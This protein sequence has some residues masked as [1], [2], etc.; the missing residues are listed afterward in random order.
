MTSGDLD[1]D[2]RG[3][4]AHAARAILIAALGGELLSWLVTELRGGELREA[5]RQVI[6]QTLF[7]RISASNLLP[8]DFKW[9]ESPRVGTA[10]ALD[11]IAAAL[12][13]DPLPTVHIAPQR[14]QASL[15]EVDYRS[16]TF[17]FIPGQPPLVQATATVPNARGEGEF[18]VTREA[19]F[20][21]D[22]YEAAFRAAMQVE[23]HD[24]LE[25]FY[26]KGQRWTDPHHLH[27]PT[28]GTT[29]AG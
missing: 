16:F 6:E 22:P 28:P 21:G 5:L 11:A 25:N 14:I 15:D 19:E 18:T 3:S 12:S 17:R 10:L 4:P 26:V 7:D 13:V 24:A 1:V 23:T 29:P 9:P 20:R 2:H 8:D 27:V